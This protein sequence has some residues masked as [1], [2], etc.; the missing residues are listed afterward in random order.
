MSCQE[1]TDL[2]IIKKNMK[3]IQETSSK[4][5]FFYKQGLKKILLS[6]GDSIK[7][8]EKEAI[9]ELLKLANNDCNKLMKFHEKQVFYLI[10]LRKPTKEEIYDDNIKGINKI[11]I[12]GRIGLIVD[13]YIV[14]ISPENKKKPIK[15]TNLN[16]SGQHG[17][18]DKYWLND[19]YLKKYKQLSID[20][21]KK[22]LLVLGKGSPFAVRKM[23]DLI[24][25]EIP[26]YLIA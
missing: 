23:S 7:T 3:K 11:G 20:H 21:I 10:Q 8:V 17:M 13:G 22:I 2:K 12:G 14:S 1:E 4:Y 6:E 25:K 15:L 18:V 9:T 26:F 5:Y 16:H 24:K 19:R